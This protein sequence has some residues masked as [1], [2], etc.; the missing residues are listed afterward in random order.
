MN[1]TAAATCGSGV[2]L[3]P[4]FLIVPGLA[5]TVGALT[6]LVLLPNDAAAAFA[7]PVC[8]FTFA[9]AAAYLLDDPSAVLTDTVP[10]DRWRRRLTAAMPGLLLLGSL[11]LLISF[12]VQPRL[13]TGGMTTASLETTALITISLAGAATRAR[14][15]ADP[16]PGS[17]IAPAVIAGGLAAL[18]V[19]PLTGARLFVAT[20]GDHRVSWSA[21][22]LIAAA[23]L[24]VESRDPARRRRYRRAITSR[25]EL[26]SPRET[27]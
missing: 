6:V 23:A 4:V 13:G 17:A 16:E 14:H 12:A 9:A 21:L 26:R 11:W 10:G 19:E 15:T 27:P 24:A 18:L 22:F 3:R 25:P 8:Q 1:L 7:L 2:A 20:G 5:A